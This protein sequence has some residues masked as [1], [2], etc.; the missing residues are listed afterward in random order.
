[1][2]S[3]RR[4]T[5]IALAGFVIAAV[6]MT[7]PVASRLRSGI[8]MDL[9]DPLL[10]SWILAWG[11]ERAM[12]ILGGEG[13]AAAGFFDANIFH[14][15]P[16]T[17]AY[18][19]HLFAQTVQVL[20]IYAATG[21]PILC[22][23]LLFLSTFVLSGLGMYLL[24]R[25]TT[26][27]AGAGFVA[28]LLYA[29]S[30]VR[31][32][33]LGH[34]QVLSSQWMPFV[35]LWLR[36]FVRTGRVAPL[37]AAT[38][39][40]VAQNLSCG[41]FLV[42]FAPFVALYALF[43]LVASRR[44]GC[45]RVWLGLMASGAAA[46]ALTVPFLLPYVELRQRGI[47][48]RSIEEVEHFSADVYSYATP[49]PDL[50]LWG[51]R[52]WGMAT[53]PEGTLFPGFAI[54]VLAA[55]GLGVE[56]RRAWQTRSEARFGPREQAAAG[57]LAAIAGAAL[58]STCLVLLAGQRV[59]AARSVS[60]GL[61]LAPNHLLVAALAGVALLAF[62]PASRRWLRAIIERVPSAFFL[63][64]SL[65][66]VWLSFGPTIESMGLVV[67][68]ETA[69]AWL[70]HNVPGFDGL[71]VPA[72]YA[73]L[74]V[75][76]LVVP[77]G[78]GLSCLLRRG[79]PA[80]LLAASFLV[81]ADGAAFPVAIHP[82]TRDSVGSEAAA[83]HAP[84]LYRFIE[85]L[86]DDAVIVEFPFGEPRDEVRYVYYSTLHWRPILNGYSGIFP[87]SY[88]ERL[89]ALRHPMVDPELAWRELRKA[90]ATH[91]IVHESMFS[92]TGEGAEVSEWL[93]E[94]GAREAAAI[95]SE[96]VFALPFAGSESGS[97]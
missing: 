87:P 13:A 49:N 95:G 22:Y 16:L 33:Q 1:M 48:P 47:Q 37:A 93:L 59:R 77:A 10:N 20:P 63:P 50:L 75:M 39:A 25:E 42:Y 51:S 12:R 29:F 92:Q 96:R 64:A 6:V 31:A 90:G 24:V 23:N 45:F 88:V 62:S 46:F 5:A 82:A 7:W 70:Y 34:L 79:N 30:P 57:L 72:R 55:A 76:F 26:G 58:A 89:A 36:R 86:P 69:Y 65:A 40:L 61:A 85:R 67:S 2:S 54:L 19:E 66:A 3:R 27:S 73:M 41:Y 78:T 35:M 18:S 53:S 52:E 43:E 74:A 60:R 15:E 14:P 11:G 94:S 4:P 81:L 38:V 71:R 9:G 97:R 56:G 84:R 68:R 21:D 28:G 80:T 44:I 17:L 83:R 8:P 32:G 91:A